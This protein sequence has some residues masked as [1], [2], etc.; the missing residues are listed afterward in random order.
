MNMADFFC[1]RDQSL[2]TFEL[3]VRFNATTKAFGTYLKAVNKDVLLNSMKF[4]LRDENAVL[5]E[6]KASCPLSLKKEEMRGFSDLY[7]P[8]DVA[9]ATTWRITCEFIYETVP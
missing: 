2:A 5:A 1:A 9:S 3:I 4:V 6:V 7:K 8:G